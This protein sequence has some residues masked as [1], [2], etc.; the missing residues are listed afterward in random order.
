MQA[1][2]L[3]WERQQAYLSPAHELLLVIC[4]LLLQVAHVLSWSMRKLLFHHMIAYSAPALRTSGL[5]DDLYTMLLA[6]AMQ[7]PAI[8]S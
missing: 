1:C 2:R 8:G 3:W 4:G 7:K 5:R 6:T